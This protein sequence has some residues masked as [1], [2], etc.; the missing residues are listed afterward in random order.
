[1]F[2]MGRRHRST[3]EDEAK[4]RSKIARAPKELSRE[5][6][7]SQT[8]PPT[9]FS[10]RSLRSTSTKIKKL[11]KPL[12]AVKALA[13]RDSLAT[14]LKLKKIYCSPS[15]NTSLTWHLN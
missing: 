9:L 7:T 14:E 3:K 1:M 6:A 12:A 8:N 4:V 11:M 10:E 5:V 15:R 2:V 13:G